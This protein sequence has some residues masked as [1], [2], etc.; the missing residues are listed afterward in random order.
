VSGSLFGQKTDTITFFSKALNQERTIY[1][2]TPLFYKYQS[3][4]VQL[5]I[6]FLL[7][8]QHDWFVNPALNSI[9][10]LQYTH[11]IPQVITVIIP[12]LDR[13]KE[14]GIERLSDNE[15]PLHRFITEDV[16][17][18]LKAYNSNHCK[19]IMGHSFSASFA[20]YSFL[21]CP[22]FYS[23]VVAHSPTDEL[24]ELIISIEEN[25]AI[26]K[27]K[28]FLSIGGSDHSKDFYHRMKYNQMKAQYPLFFNQIR[29]F[30]A[31]SSS[32]NAV[33]IVATPYFLSEL[34]ADFSQRFDSIAVVNMDYELVK[35]PADPSVEMTMITTNS[36]IFGDNYTPE[37]PEIN[38]IASRYWNNGYLDHTRQ[39]FEYGV[40]LYPNYYEFHV[41]LVELYTEVS[42]EKALFHLTKAIE[43]LEA[44]EDELPEKDALINDLNQFKRSNGW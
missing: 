16:L 14:C 43:L 24:E 11:E 37:I 12:L 17:P 28:V 34:F 6:V 4:K 15:M 5:P 31:N 9:D 38:G 27:S 44:F 19:I 2:R 26:D 22:G 8:G 10:Y 35:T 39:L 36:K 42:K 13:N 20:L 41:A 25:E 18:E 32:H 29:T 40:Q 21:K 3:E 30:E 23:A 1:V 7:D 33:P